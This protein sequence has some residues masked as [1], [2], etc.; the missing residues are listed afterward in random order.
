MIKLEIIFK[1][2]RNSKSVVACDILI[3]RAYEQIK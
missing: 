1:I 3:S 2:K